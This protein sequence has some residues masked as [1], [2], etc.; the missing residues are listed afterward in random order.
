MLDF[1]RKKFPSCYIMLYDNPNGSCQKL[2]SALKCD[3]LK[4][5]SWESEEGKVFTGG[6]K[7][8]DVK[9]KVHIL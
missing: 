2:C 8:E 6:Q 9:K 1:H 3:L 5:K 4:Y 7:A